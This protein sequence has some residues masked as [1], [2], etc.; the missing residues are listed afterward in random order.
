[1]L[2]D[3]L[4]RQADRLLWLLAA[5]VFIFTVYVFVDGISTVGSIQHSF[6][7]NSAFSLDRGRQL[8]VR[9][10]KRGAFFTETAV[11]LIRHKDGRLEFTKGCKPVPLAA[12][13]VVIRCDGVFDSRSL[14]SIES[15]NS[16]P[17]RYAPIV[18]GIQTHA[19]R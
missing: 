3:W 14:V 10:H 11:I 7:E 4:S 19:L 1:M 18:D 17:P 12:D 2:G 15:S 6:G 9:Y 13:L 5:A 16:D 8:E